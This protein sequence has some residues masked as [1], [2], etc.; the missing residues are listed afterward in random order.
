MVLDW[1]VACK[2][3]ELLFRLDTGYV[4]YELGPW[5]LYPKYYFK[6]QNVENRGFLINLW[7]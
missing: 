2:G 3:Y 1:I 5:D 6:A 4:I 7:D